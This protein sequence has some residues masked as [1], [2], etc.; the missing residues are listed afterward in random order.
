MQVVNR[1]LSWF[2]I[3]PQARKRFHE[4]ELRLL[5]ESLKVKQLQPVLAKSDGTLIAGER[6]YRAAVLVGL[7]HL[8][9]LVADEPL[10][11]SQFR[12]IQLSEN[13][14][15]ADLTPVERFQACEELLQ[16]NPT[17]NLKELADR[18]TKRAVV[19]LEEEDHAA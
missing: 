2:K 18:M 1:P 3:A 17:W 15:R 14:H 10:S 5:G 16:L 19:S 4:D 12:V 8:L 9:V 13:I 6:R 11:D 7:T